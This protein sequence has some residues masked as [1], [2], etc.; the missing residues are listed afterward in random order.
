MAQPAARSGVLA[1]KVGMTRVFGD[2]G[3]HIPVTVLS[4]DGCQV[5]GVRTE[6]VRTVKTKKGGE[7]TRT[8]GYKAVILGAGEKKAKRTPKAE[9]AAF[10]KA[11]VAPKAKLKEFRVTGNLPEVGS[12]VLADHF[13][14]G[15][16]VDVSAIST[17]KGFA[18]AMKRWNF[19]GLR[20]THGVSISHRSH[21]STGMRQDPGR[22]FK[23]KKMAGHLGVDRITTQNLTVVR[24]D[25]ERGLILVKGSV[26]GVD[27]AFVEI[28]DAVK[29]ALP[30]DAPAAGSFKAPEKLTAG[31]E[32]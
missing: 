9:R 29:K 18:G 23:N 11:G 7:V 2:D 6:E 32:G 25:V 20:A 1:R 27:G 28:R 19:S 12:T 14:P 26:P 22:V 13:V 10:A 8:D 21:G 15:Q 16:K 24:T 5:V 30:K 3:R 31:G 4:L 17:G